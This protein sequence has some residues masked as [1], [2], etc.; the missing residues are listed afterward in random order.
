MKPSRASGCPTASA[1]G[2]RSRG[3]TSTAVAGRAA[4][5]PRWRLHALAST[6]GALV[7]SIEAEPHDGAG[8]LDGMAEDAE[9]ADDDEPWSLGAGIPPLPGDDAAAGYERVRTLPPTELAGISAAGELLSRLTVTSPHHRLV[10]RY[11]VL[12]HAL[13]EVLEPGTEAL[14]ARLLRASAALR[15]WA[16]HA[17][18]LP[19]SFA[20]AFGH[21]LREGATTASEEWRD[22]VARELCSAL[23]GAGSIHPGGGG[24]LVAMAPPAPAGGP[25]RRRRRAAGLGTSERI[26]CHVLVDAEP[27][28]HDASRL[29]RALESE[30]L[31]GEPLLMRMSGTKLQLQELHADARTTAEGA[32]RVA[33]RVLA[34]QASEAVAEG[35]VQP[36]A[37]AGGE[38]EASSMDGEWRS[39]PDSSAAGSVEATRAGEPEVETEVPAA[40]AA[41][42]AATESAESEEGAR[43]GVQP[44]MLPPVDITAVAA[45]LAESVSELERVWSDAVAPDKALGAAN[46]DEHRFGSVAAALLRQS[47]EANRRARDDG[48]SAIP[49]FPLSDDELAALDPQQPTAPGSH[50]HLVP[51]LY[52]LQAFLHELKAISQPRELTFGIGGVVTHLAFDPGAVGRLKAQAV[53][54]A[55]CAE[56]SEAG[57]SDDTTAAAGADAAWLRAAAVRAFAAGLPEA[58]VLYAHLVM[59]AGGDLRGLESVAAS[60]C[61][62]LA[63]GG[64]AQEALPVTIPLA[65]HLAAVLYDSDPQQGRDQGASAGGAAGEGDGCGGGPGAGST[66]PAEPPS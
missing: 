48:T 25:A 6:G 36:A 49:N 28:L 54:L 66:P 65:H 23:A 14:E 29:L 4:K 43:P 39:E 58:V 32:V 44:P 64:T 27:E 7:A 42:E 3:G 63:A 35:P 2:S 53:L 12:D 21:L 51:P 5:Q 52:V 18:E 38:A 24:P 62:H 56:A 60:V 9:P 46:R 19:A 50:M 57:E 33:K 41:A 37:H 47:E 15:S 22:G 1:R 10:D 16:R 61:A 30:V 34:A 20:A 11:Q 17:A 40:E 8:T 13:R 26:H 59:A 55:R 45:V 31:L